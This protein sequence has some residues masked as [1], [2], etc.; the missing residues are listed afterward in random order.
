[1]LAPLWWLGKIIVAL[2]KVVNISIFHSPS[3]N[4]KLDLHVDMVAVDSVDVLFNRL[5]A[6][7]LAKNNDHRNNSL[8]YIVIVLCLSLCLCVFL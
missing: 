2:S 5:V 4:V 1:M 3:S 8:V 6:L 7:L